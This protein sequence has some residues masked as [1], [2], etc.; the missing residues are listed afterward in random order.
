MVH[1]VEAYTSRTKNNPISDALAVKGLQ[2]LWD[3]FERAMNQ[4]DDVEARAD[5]LLGKARNVLS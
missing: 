2:M 1:Y 3:N 5:M 4:G